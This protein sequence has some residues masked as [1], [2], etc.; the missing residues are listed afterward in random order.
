MADNTNVAF[1]DGYQTYFN[2]VTGFA[3]AEANITST[4]TIDKS[5]EGKVYV[6]HFT[7]GSKIVVGYKLD[8]C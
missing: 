1:H 6:I 4:E 2:F 5:F 8:G 3:Q 7:D